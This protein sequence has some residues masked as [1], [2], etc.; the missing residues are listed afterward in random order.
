MSKISRKF[1]IL[2]ILSIGL[3]VLLAS[4]TITTYLLNE[5]SKERHNMNLM[6]LDGL[7]ENISSF[8]DLT[9]ML[10]LQLSINSEIKP[11][12]LNVNPIWEHR[13]KEYKG[14]D[15][16]AQLQKKYEFVEL[17]F[18]QDIKGDQVARSSGNLG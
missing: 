7:K 3:P 6:Y 4:F 17:F 16:F 14:L 1:N 15:L 9:D 5:S 11:S 10:N 2:L 13:L 8:L 12:L 18:L